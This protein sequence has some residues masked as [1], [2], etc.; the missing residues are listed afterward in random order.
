MWH[1]LSETILALAESFDVSPASGLTLTDVLVDLPLE[2]TSAV[3]H[4]QLIVYATPPFTRYKSG[5][6][7]QVHTSHLA[8]ALMETEAGSEERR[9]G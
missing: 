3:Q 6:L 5:V 1:E 9:N 7:P 2:V 8:F 4:G